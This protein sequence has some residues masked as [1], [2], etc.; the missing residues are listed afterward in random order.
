[1]TPH[2][3]NY[4]TYP[5]LKTTQACDNK[6]G[7]HHG[8]VP[9]CK[10]SVTCYLEFCHMNLTI[11]PTH[12]CPTYPWDKKPVGNIIF[13]LCGGKIATFTNHSEGSSLISMQKE[14]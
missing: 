12:G 5:P 2:Y 9:K 6:L 1:M 14:A 4:D 8:I 3:S 10:V 13:R 11:I 7:I